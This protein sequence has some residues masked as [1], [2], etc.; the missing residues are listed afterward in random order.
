M[1]GAYRALNF[2]VR[3]LGSLTA[4]TLGTAIGTRPILW[5]ATSGALLGV[6][7][8]LPSPLLRMRALPLDDGGPPG[9]IEY[10]D[11][12]PGKQHQTPPGDP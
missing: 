10:D 4:G 6:L 2:G 3:P 11:F 12:H 9:T 8:L 7:W 1:T 5:I